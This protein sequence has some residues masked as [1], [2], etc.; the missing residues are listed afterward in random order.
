LTEI[1]EAEED[2]K[3]NFHEAV[4]LLADLKSSEETT[5]EDEDEL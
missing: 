4:S 1:L 2:L 3:A 5:D